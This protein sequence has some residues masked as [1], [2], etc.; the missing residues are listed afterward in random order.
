M[1]NKEREM[2]RTKNIENAEYLKR[3]CRR[4]KE[5]I[6]LMGITQADVIAKC[7]NNGFK[8]SKPMLSKMLKDASGA[9]MMN[10]AQIAEALGLNLNELCSTRGDVT[11]T[12]PNSRQETLITNANDH[13]FDRYKGLYYIRMFRTVSYEG[14]MIGGTLRI[15]ELPGSL[16]MGV[17]ICIEVNQNYTLNSTI[18]KDYIGT[19]KYSSKMHVLYISATSDELGED[20]Y[21]IFP[22]LTLSKEDLFCRLGLALVCSAGANKVPT[23]ERVLIT[24]R[25]LTDEEIRYIDGQL[26]L[27]NSEIKISKEQFSQLRDGYR[28]EDKLPDAFK[29]LFID[30][31]GEL[32]GAVTKSFYCINEA[33]IRN[34]DMNFVDQMKSVCL[35]R[36]Y[37]DAP[38][39]TKVSTKANELIYRLLNEINPIEASK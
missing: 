14:D 6:G 20:V 27:N 17:R 28:G 22:Y 16:D 21:L 11:I 15:E 7:D 34:S 31:S 39:Y 2:A 1:D 23:A 9:T 32:K 5:A 29:R 3:V 12:I 25:E 30:D 18:K 10:I 19:V 24:K 33:T 26:L 38:R 37:S 13:C 4:L 8:I 36:K 35:L